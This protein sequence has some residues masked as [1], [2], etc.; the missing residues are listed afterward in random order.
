MFDRLAS[1]LTVLVLRCGF[2]VRCYAGIGHRASLALLSVTDALLA[3]SSTD[4]LL[5]GSLSAR[6]SAMRRRADSFCSC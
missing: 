1:H 3:G 2:N 6:T 4:A 5:A